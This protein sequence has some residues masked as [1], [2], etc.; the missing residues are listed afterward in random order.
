MGIMFRELDAWRSPAAWQSRP[1][2]MPDPLRDSLGRP[3][4]RLGR[5]YGASWLPGCC[6]PGMPARRNI[7][8][9]RMYRV[10]SY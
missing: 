7:P 3:E 10:S 5:D 9:M 1:D 4:K 6:L 2:G 8:C